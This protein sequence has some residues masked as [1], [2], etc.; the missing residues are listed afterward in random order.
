[1]EELK[2]T[3]GALENSEKGKDVAKIV[4]VAAAG[5]GA[6]ALSAWAL[7][8]YFN[9]QVQHSGDDDVT[10]A[11]EPAVDDD[12]T[13][14]GSSVQI[15]AVSGDDVETATAI[16]VADVAAASVVE[17]SRLNGD[18]V[19]IL[20]TGQAMKDT[21]T[22]DGE[23]VPSIYIYK[24]NDQFLQLV[25]VGVGDESYIVGLAYDE[26]GNEVMYIDYDHDGRFDVR[27][28]SVDG[29]EDFSQIEE[30]D[31]FGY[32]YTVEYFQAQLEEDGIEPIYNWRAETDPAADGNSIELVSLSQST[33]G[34]GLDDEYTQLTATFRIGRH[35]MTFIDYDGDGAFDY[36]A[37]DWN[38]DGQID[39]NE[40]RTL[41][42]PVGVNVIFDYPLAEDF[43]DPDDVYNQ[44]IIDND[45]ILHTEDVPVVDKFDFIE[46]VADG[47]D[48]ATVD[49][50]EDAGMSIDEQLYT[51]PDNLITLENPDTDPHFSYGD[52]DVIELGDEPFE[53]D[54]PQADDLAL[55]TDMPQAHDLD[56]APEDDVTA[57]QTEGFQPVADDAV[58]VSPALDNFDDYDDATIDGYTI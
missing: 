46:E 2:Q 54:E 16:P 20:E 38:H 48:V 37:C 13:I 50:G 45:Y 7:G 53:D 10:V 31:D 47:I 17:G 6:G 18:D 41:D 42:E 11:D 15:V 25:E 40:M 23:Y 5:L 43:T 28:A 52:P 55:T 49:D 22:D 36:V 57:G 9:M 30:L 33:I 27:A 14:D 1:M 34:L 35:D 4:A 8:G 26:E 19:E 44:L 12:E 58:N 39:P 32:E 29:D 51:N 24:Y 3:S 56:L 21:A